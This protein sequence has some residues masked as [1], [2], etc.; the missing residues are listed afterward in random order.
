[1]EAQLFNIGLQWLYPGNFLEKAK[2]SALE[3]Q[4][5]YILN[6]DKKNYATNL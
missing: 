3:F 1:M 5:S 6:F 4:G 2:S